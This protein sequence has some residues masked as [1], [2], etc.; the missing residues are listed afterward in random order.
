MCG[1]SP[2]RNSWV[3]LPIVSRDKSL[4]GFTKMGPSPELIPDNPDFLP[5]RKIIWLT[6]GNTT[7]QMDGV[8]ESIFEAKLVK[9]IGLVFVVR[10]TI[11]SHHM[12]ESTKQ[13]EQKIR[14]TGHSTGIWQ[15]HVW[16][17]FYLEFLLFTL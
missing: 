14:I 4:Q 13:W 7:W 11:T 10:F 2:P 8:M 9:R 1:E 6:F 5:V 16:S 15:L 17:F 12:L 3:K